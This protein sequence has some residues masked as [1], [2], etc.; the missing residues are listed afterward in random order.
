MKAVNLSCLVLTLMLTVA[1]CDRELTKS[2]N[3]RYSRFNLTTAEVELCSSRR[4]QRKRFQITTDQKITKNKVGL[5]ELAKQLGNVSRACNIVGEKG[6]KSFN[7][8]LSF[9]TPRYL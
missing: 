6:D 8:S 7:L 4:A 9:H 2:P 1:M 3:V 5:L